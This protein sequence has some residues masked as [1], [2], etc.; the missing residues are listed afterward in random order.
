MIHS[1]FGFKQRDE[2]KINK[3]CIIMYLLLQITIIK[4]YKLKTA[5]IYPKM[6]NTN[7]KRDS[8][9]GVFL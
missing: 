6:I 9:R 1:F 2:N 7:E 5:I 8:V 3:I 4:S